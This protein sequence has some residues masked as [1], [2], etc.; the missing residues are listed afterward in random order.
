[1]PRPGWPRRVIQLVRE[2][3][4][5]FPLIG[6]VRGGDRADGAPGNGEDFERLLGSWDE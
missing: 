1:M 2:K 3:K 6:A 5:P 4:V